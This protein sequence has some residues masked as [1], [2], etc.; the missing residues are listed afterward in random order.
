[1]SKSQQDNS[2]IVVYGP[3]SCGKSTHAKALAK[4]YGKSRVVDDWTPGA[5]LS[6]DTIALTN[7]PHAGAIDF[8]DATAAA[9]ISLSPATVRRIKEADGLTARG[10]L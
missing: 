9:G 5:P 1:M 10:G 8:W 6:A 7:F 3:H 4:H 2:A